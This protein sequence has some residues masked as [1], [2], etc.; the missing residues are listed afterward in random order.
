M[1]VVP[2]SVW[3]GDIDVVASRYIF[4]GMTGVNWLRGLNNEAIRAYILT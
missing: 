2:A 3:A 4:S 1:G